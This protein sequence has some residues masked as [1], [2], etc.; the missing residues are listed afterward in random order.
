MEDIKIDDILLSNCPKF[1]DP[2]YDCLPPCDCA[3]I[4]KYSFLEFSVDSGKYY[5]RDIVAS[6]WLSLIENE[7]IIVD[8]LRNN[9]Q[10]NDSEKIQY[11][12]RNLW[13][14][15]NTEERSGDLTC[16]LLTAIS[17]VTHKYGLELIPVDQRF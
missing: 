8:F 9:D 6:M 10:M 16:V 3:L 12:A 15:L 14:R 7:T 1:L 11:V 2:V 17:I 5:F 13:S 4:E